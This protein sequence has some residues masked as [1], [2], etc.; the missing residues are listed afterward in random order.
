M[1]GTIGAFAF[2]AGLFDSSD[3][4]DYD[5]S[6]LRPKRK[7]GMTVGATGDCYCHH[8]TVYGMLSD[9]VG[10]KISLWHPLPLWQYPR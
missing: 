5:A 2:F 1:I 9:A 7:V 10:R 4:A 8:V 3:F 6:I